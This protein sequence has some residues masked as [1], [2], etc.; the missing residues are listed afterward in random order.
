[1]EDFQQNNPGFSYA[2]RKGDT[3]EILTNGEMSITDGRIAIPPNVDL[4]FIDGGHSIE[5]IRNDYEAVKGAKVVVLDDFYVPQDDEPDI[6]KFG[7]N[8]LL[9]E[10]DDVLEL[11]IKNPVR[12]GGKVR[13]ALTPTSA[14]PGK[15]QL[16]IKTKNCV[17]NEEIHRNIHYSMPKIDR[18]IVECKPHTGL[19]VLVSSGPTFENHLEDIRQYASGVRDGF[20]VTVKHAHDTLIEKGIIPWACILLDPRDHV[21]DF[22]ENPHPDVIYFVASMCHPTT[23]DRLLSSG[24]KVWGYHAHVGADEEKVLREYGKQIMVGG[25]STS[26]VRGISVL[27]CLGFRR[28]HLYG[29]DSCYYEKPDFSL[30]TKTGAQKYYEVEVLGRKF[31]SDSEL[32]AQAQDFEKLI[33]TE[34]DFQEME[35][36]G[37]GMIPHIWNLKRLIRPEFAEVMDG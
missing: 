29:Y 9:S 11:P 14:W 30:K 34:R 19:A 33:K 12:G 5:T 26:A 25:G 23:L 2:L 22:I 3:R 31:W 15:A 35:V 21:Q 17:P 18:W 20:I 27:H 1:L 4:A 13:M 6:T 7:C 24:A 32:I 8:A 36:F 16:V 10:L 28:Y 37:E